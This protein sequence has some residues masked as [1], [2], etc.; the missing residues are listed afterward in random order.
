[1]I[2]ISKVSHTWIVFPHQYLRVSCQKHSV[3][4]C[5]TWFQGRNWVASM[6]ELTLIFS[7]SY[8]CHNINIF[9]PARFVKFPWRCWA[10][11]S[12]SWK[13]VRKTLKSH[14]N[15]RSLT[16]LSGAKIGFH[17]NSRDWLFWMFMVSKI[18][19]LINKSVLFWQDV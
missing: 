14:K 5:L 2:F 16:D 15:L 12:Q 9:W 1:M 10:E 6:I 18:N 17:S 8:V 7:P 4:T 11:F 13:E 19:P 3:S